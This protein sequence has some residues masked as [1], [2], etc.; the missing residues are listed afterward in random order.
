MNANYTS[1]I[2]AQQRLNVSSELVQL[3][4]YERQTRYK[5]QYAIP[6]IVFVA[7]YGAAVM[8]ALLLW[9]MRRTKF[10]MLRLLL[11]K[12]SVGRAI[13]VERHK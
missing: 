8:V 1:S 10:I 9:A 5:L 3:L 6:A 2:D 11:K 4:R 7:F 12:A 13:T